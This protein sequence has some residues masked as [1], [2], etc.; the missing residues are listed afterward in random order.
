MSAADNDSDNYID[1]DFFQLKIYFRKTEKH[2][3]KKKIS[4][5]KKKRFDTISKKK[6]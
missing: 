1:Q 4:S 5:L 2:S 6:F 3:Q